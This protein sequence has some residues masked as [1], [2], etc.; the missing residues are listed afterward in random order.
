MEKTTRDLMVPLE[1]YVTVSD[2][3]TLKDAVVALEKAQEELDRKRYRYVHRA[4]LVLNK[5]KE[6]VGKISQLDILKGLEPNYK[7]IVDTTKR[8]SVSGFSTHFLTSMMDLHRL[9]ANP[10][11]DICSKAAKIKVQEFM[12]TPTE[13]EVIDEK[14]SLEEAMHIMVMGHHHSLLV[15]RDGKIVGV[16]RLTD[17][18]IYI[19]DLIKACSI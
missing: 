5:K 14:V 15:T 3:A 12:T 11:S 9:W 4:V 19:N 13:G 18:C 10:L 1:E 2:E 6:V 16:L 17:V 7:K 8:I